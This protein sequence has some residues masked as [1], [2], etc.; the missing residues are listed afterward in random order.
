MRS[1]KWINLLSAVGPVLAFFVSVAEAQPFTTVYS[2]TNGSD[3]SLPAAG[4]ILSGNTLY[5]TACYGG[6]QNTNGTVF[7]LSTDGTGFET[8]YSFTGGSDGSGPVGS[9]ILLGNT[10]YGTASRGGNSGNGT[11]FSLNTDGTGF[12]ILHTF[13]GRSDGSDPSAG[14]ILSGNTLYGTAFSGGD[15]KNGTVFSLNT[16]GTGFKTLYAFTGGSDGGSPEA[17]LIL[18]GNTLYG[19]AVY[20]GD[21]GW[22][23]VFSL[24]TNG[25]G[26]TT[27]HSFT[28]GS[29]G[30]SPTAGLVLSGNMLY[31]TASSGGSQNTNGTVF[32]LNTDGTG[33][34]TLYSF[35]GGSDGFD[36][37]AGLILSGSTL[38]GTALQGGNAGIGL[39]YSGGG[40]MFSL[41]TNGMGFKT[42]YAFTGGSDGS[43][44]EAGLILSGSTLYG[45]AGQGGD[46]GWGSVF[47]LNSSAQAF[48]TLRA[49]DS[50]SSPEA[51]LL[52]SAN[53]LYGTAFSGGDSGNGAVFSLNT[54]GSAPTTLYRFSATDINGFNSDGADPAAGLILLSNTLYGT[55]SQGGNSGYGTVFSLQTNGGVFTCLHNFTGGSDGAAPLAGLILS[56]NTLYGTA[57]Q[58]GNSGNGTIFSLNINGTGFDTLYSFSPTDSNGFN[59]DGAEPLGALILSGNTLYGT[60]DSGGYWGSGTVFSLNTDGTGFATVYTFS[61]TN[62]NGFNSDGTE[63]AAGLIL[64]GATLYGTTSGGGNSGNGTVFSLKT[65]G[66]GFATLYGFSAT[67]TNGFNSDG[68]VPKTALILS[69]NTLYGTA[70]QGGNSGNGTI[71]SLNT[72][73]TDFTTLYSFCGGSDGSD[74]IGNLLLAGNTLYG[75]AENAGTSS[76][77]TVFALKVS[78]SSIL[79]IALTIQSRGHSLVLSWN[80]PSAAFSLQ[81]APTVNGVFTNVPG[82]TSPFTNVITGS[83]QFFRLMAPR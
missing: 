55:A 8:L 29:D 37:P 30:A 59:N 76:G 68:A 56:G 14:L 54:N 52:L 24:R 49:F 23:S 77:G 75:T 57:S 65:N 25:T 58:G 18:S 35:T 6:F 80:D 67:D 82:A 53:T 13:T 64:S 28:N 62:S 83:A 27:L 21:S 36:P 12:K 34:T 41:N 39:P 81:A 78:G 3:G 22:G 5:G 16:N 2:F 60:A 19:T 79:P 9:L 1:I 38:Y 45:T 50:A 44:P 11:V 61:R 4:V 20:G 32:A 47:A 73:G 69:G 72:N 33:F 10:L 66:A 43:S 74:P 15:A 51:G 63:P 17:G 48:T 42:L 70:S 26:F 46:S 40:T 31:G 7:A 71:F